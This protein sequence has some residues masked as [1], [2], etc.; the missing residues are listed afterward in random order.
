MQLYYDK[1]EIGDIQSA[2]VMVAAPVFYLF[3]VPPSP[4]SLTTSSK[5]SASP[6][7]ASILDRGSTTSGVVFLFTG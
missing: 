7:A 4:L 1:N 3:M 6:R 2:K 5:S